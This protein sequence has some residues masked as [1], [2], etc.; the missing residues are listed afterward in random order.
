MTRQLVK[1]TYNNNQP[2]ATM[3]YTEAV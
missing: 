3:T 2:I 1:T